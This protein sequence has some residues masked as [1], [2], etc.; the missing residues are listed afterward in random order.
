M[1]EEFQENNLNHHLDISQIY[2][3]EVERRPVNKLSDSFLRAKKKPRINLIKKILK[4]TCKWIYNASFDTNDHLLE[5]G[6]L[7]NLSKIIITFLSIQT[8]THLSVFLLNN[9][10][11]FSSQSLLSLL[12]NYLANKNTVI[13]TSLLAHSITNMLAI[14]NDHKNNKDKKTSINPYQKSNSHNE[15]IIQCIKAIK[16]NINI[17]IFNINCFR[18]VHK[19]DPYELTK[20]EKK[21]LSKNMTDLQQ[22]L[23]IFLETIGK[24]QAESSL[25]KINR[26]EEDIK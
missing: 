5:N 19:E 16:Y 22:Y 23:V 17:I 24:I 13:L 14:N 26:K 7:I 4:S 21:C 8:I 10:N 20:E 3:H 6:K 11:S 15:E 9:K 1:H 18:I 12:K 25:L 2:R